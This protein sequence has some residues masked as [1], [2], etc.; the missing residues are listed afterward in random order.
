MAIDNFIVVNNKS[1]DLNNLSETERKRLEHMKLHE[2]HKGHEKMHLEMFLILVVCLIITQFIL[3]QWRQRHLRSFQQAT[4]F[5]MW[6]VPMIISL[7]NVWYRFI[8][9]WAVFSL[10]MAFMAFSATRKPIAMTTPS[11]VYTWFLLIYKL[12][13]FF[14]IIGYL[15]IMSTLF[16]LNI[17]FMIKPAAAMDFGFLITFYGLYFGV[18][19][20]DLSAVCSDKMA[21]Q[22]GYYTESGVPTR[23]LDEHVCAVCGN[24]LISDDKDK[25]YKL[26][27][28]HTFH[29][30][31]IRGWCIVG[32]KQTCPY[33]RERVDL[34][35]MFKNPWEKPHL[36]YGS[37]LD[38]VR[39]LVAWQPLIFIVI[40]GIF[41]TFGLK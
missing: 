22:I 20:R 12:S 36:L 40:Q 32:K 27:C 33:C 17:L 19:G 13:Y 26:N 3:I 7:Y 9:I 11:R 15:V 38:W 31:C 37:L 39:Y 34:Q 24:P 30:F 23:I 14:G 5:G 35:R 6:I 18:V 41:L 25:C 1:Y 29:D 16:G 4:L 21:A 2:E 28:G 10:I 8:I